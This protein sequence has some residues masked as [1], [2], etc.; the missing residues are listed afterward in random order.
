MEEEEQNNDSIIILL[1]KAFCVLCAPPRTRTVL[2]NADDPVPNTVAVNIYLLLR[3]YCLLL[4]RNRSIIV[5]DVVQETF[6]FVQQTMNDESSVDSSCLKN[7]NNKY[8]NLRTI[9][10]I[11]FNVVS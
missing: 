7:I 11:E 1:L 10:F 2:Q 9:Q 5:F 3:L 8:S 4:R 6:A